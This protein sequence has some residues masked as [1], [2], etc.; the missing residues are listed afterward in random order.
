MFLFPQ[1]GMM[2]MSENSVSRN[3]DGKVQLTLVIHNHQPV[4]N[5]DHVFHLACDKAYLP[6]LSMLQ[7]FPRLRIGLHTSG[8]LWEWLEAHR[9]EYGK[10]VDELLA[11]GQL[12]LL[13]G[14]MYEPILPVLPERDAVWQ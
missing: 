6:F 12:E 11:D 2:D 3:T 13:G 10:L 5:F 9:P 4:G 7:E 14:G 8:C 1:V